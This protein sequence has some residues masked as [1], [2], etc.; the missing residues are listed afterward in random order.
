MSTGLTLQVLN[1]NDAYSIIKLINRISNYQ[2]INNILIIDNGSTDNSLAILKSKYKYNEQV[3]LIKTKKNGGYGYGHNFGIRYVKEKLKSKYV[4]IA[5]PG[6]FFA[7]STVKSMLQLAIE[8][9]A[10]IVSAT[11]KIN[12]KVSRNA[13]WKIPSAIQWTLIESRLEPL[14]FKKYHYDKSYF[15]NSYSKVD[16]VLGA[17]FMVNVDDF[18][19]VGGYDERMFLFGEETLLGFKFKRKG[20]VTYILNH[21]FYEHPKST[22]ISKNLPNVLQQDMITHHSKVI[23]MRNYL[24][25][26]KITLT[27]VKIFFKLKEKN[28]KRK[29]KI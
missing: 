12:H 6:V 26:N 10:G 2:I 1:Y 15:F 23:F 5:S 28:A 4:I 24:K 8:K 17:M 9:D 20:Y 22:T 7:E 13:A 11:Q 16:C 25:I 21:H 3:K 19:N 14:F 27:G 29:L 18:L